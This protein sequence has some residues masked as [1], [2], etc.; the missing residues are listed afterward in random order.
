MEIGVEDTVAAK[1]VYGV[2]GGLLTITILPGTARTVIPASEKALTAPA[3]NTPDKA[4]A[5]ATKSVTLGAA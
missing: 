5:A 4:L 1:G 2:T 3:L